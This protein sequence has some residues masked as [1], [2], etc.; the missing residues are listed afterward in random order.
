MMPTTRVAHAAGYGLSGGN[1]L[2]HC[3]TRNAEFNLK[4]EGAGVPGRAVISP[5]VRA[6]KVGP[7][8]EID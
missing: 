3:R 5:S 6:D 7:G 8:T 1:L 4:N 2:I